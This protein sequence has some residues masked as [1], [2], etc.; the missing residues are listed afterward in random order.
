M[1]IDL[2]LFLSLLFLITIFAWKEGGA[3]ERAV[4]VAIIVETAFDL[5]FAILVTPT[6]FRSVSGI[7]FAFDLA[8]LLAFSSIA[9]QANRSWPLVVAAAQVIVACGHVVGL[10][11]DGMQ[12]AYWALTQ[13]PLFVQLLAL[14]MGAAVHRK[15]RKSGLNVPDWTVF[16]TGRQNERSA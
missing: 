2:W 4:A 13:L 14:L 12:R 11:G 5:S 6:P 8:L 7:V 10:V 16:D 3:P 1:T 15:R 9:L